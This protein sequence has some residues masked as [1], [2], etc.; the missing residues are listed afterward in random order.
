MNLIEKATI[1]HY[2]RH[3]IAACPPGGHGALGWRAEESQT[4][5]FEVLA[6]VGDFAGASVLDIGCGHGDFKTFLDRR[7]ERFRYIGIDLMPEFVALARERYAGRPDTHFF[8]SDFASAEL[9]EADYV[10]ASGALGYRCQDPEFP[11]RMIAKFFR[12]ARCGLAFN[13]L[14]AAVFPAHDLLV[15]HDPRTVLE[16]CRSLSANVRLVQ[17]YLEDDFTVLVWP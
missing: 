3:R 5:R 15:G 11:R 1:L 10:I 9:P 8:H 4:R 13:L 14:D 6:E 2:H 12:A 17:G 16:L 7:F